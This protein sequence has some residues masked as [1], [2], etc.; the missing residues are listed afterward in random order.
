MDGA[1]ALYPIYSAFARALYPEEQIEGHLLC[2]TTTGAW[3]AIVR[4]DADIIFTAAP[5]REQ[6]QE[7]EDRGVT[8]NFIPIGKEAFVFFVN[9]KIPSRASPW[10]RYAPSTP[11]R[12]PIGGIW[13]YH[14][15]DGSEPSS[16][17]RAAAA[18]AP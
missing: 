13:T 6:L 15:W 17:S 14:P 1:T 9:A 3:D 7:A 16:A 4:G 2:S 12:R 10:P 18:R 5:S 8:L 11:A